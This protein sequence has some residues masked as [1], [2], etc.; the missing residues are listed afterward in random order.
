MKFGTHQ[1]W[2][3]P[4]KLIFYLLTVLDTKEEKFNFKRED[5]SVRNEFVQKIENEFGCRADRDGFATAQNALYTKF[6]TENKNALEQNWPKRETIWSNSPWSLWKKVAE[7]LKKS[8]CNAIC[9]LPRR[10]NTNSTT[11]GFF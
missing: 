10:E 3:V 9:I 5:Y 4:E 7:K 11:L 1:K 2:R 8:Q 6:W